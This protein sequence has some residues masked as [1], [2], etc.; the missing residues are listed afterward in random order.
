MLFCIW[1]AVTF[2]TGQGTWCDFGDLH[3]CQHTP[4]YDDESSVGQITELTQL[5][6]QVFPPAG[7]GSTQAAI[8]AA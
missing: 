6:M 4:D 8:D 7:H 3:D 1:R 2:G 5:L